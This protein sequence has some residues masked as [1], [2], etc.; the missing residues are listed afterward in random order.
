M[1]SASIYNLCKRRLTVPDLSGGGAMS[2]PCLND[3][4]DMT[5]PGLISIDNHLA[6]SKR[7]SSLH[8]D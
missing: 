3:Q 2:S 7:I 4:S 6:V 8:R 1:A 5:E